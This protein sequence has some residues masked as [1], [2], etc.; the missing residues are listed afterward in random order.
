VWVAVSK[1]S[2]VALVDSGIAR[3]GQTTVI[4]NPIES[5][6]SPP[7]HHEGPVTVGF[8]GTDTPRKGFDLLPEVARRLDG[9]GT[10]LLIFSRHHTDLDERYE[11]IWSELEQCAGVDIV[12]R[13]DDVDAGY[14]RCDIVFCPSRVESFCRVA[15]ESMRHGIPVVATDLDPIKELLGDREA[16]LVFHTGD[17]DAAAAALRT[18]AADEELRRTM[19]LNGIERAASFDPNRIATEFERLYSGASGPEPLRS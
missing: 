15:A 13:L 9:F 8:F 6:G 19:G 2:Q 18:L 11:A 12:G 10:T 4:G 16:G 1:A 14:A 5:A 17:V 7:R 3:A